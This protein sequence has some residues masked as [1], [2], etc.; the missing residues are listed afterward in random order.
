MSRAFRR[1]LLQD[2]AVY[3][4]DF[5][6]LAGE[7]PRAVQ[8]KGA[9]IR[10]LDEFQGLAFIESRDMP[11]L[12]RRLLKRLLILKIP[13]PDFAERLRIWKSILSERP[14]GEMEDLAS[15]F[16][17][18]AG[19]IEDAISAARNLAS[20]EGREQLCR[21]DIFE[22]CRMQS[23][24]KLSTLARRIVPRYR[25]EDV[26]L[27]SNG[28]EQLR[29]IEAYI[30][31][32]GKVFGEWG[33]GKKLSLGKGLNILFTG[34]SGTGKTMAAEALAHELGL[35][36]YKV[37]L[38]IVVSKYIGETEKNLSRIFAE[39][40]ESN[41]ILFFDEADAIFGKRSEVKD[42]H[43]RYANVEIG[44]LLQKMEEHEGIVVLATNL[45]RNLDEAFK[46]RMHFVVK[47]PFPGEES[48]LQIWKSL[49]PA[50]AR[51]AD[52]L[53]F[54]F[55]ARSFQI[56]G[57]NIKNVLVTAA[58][59]AAEDGGVISMKHLVRA[60]AREM[61]KIGKVCTESEFREYYDLVKGK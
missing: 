1:A 31:H 7:D 39:A 61:K 56:A 22:G 13:K 11:D 24:R 48:R 34:D 43:D 27:P 59:L 26:V 38:S 3:V 45:D 2:A 55:L 6:S 40:E 19:Q 53:D 32:Q 42:A 9:L 36:L 52:G 18:T 10:A 5:D 47:F 51:V 46:R 41:A 4:Q 12:G 21:E 49:L 17:L 28:T 37:D 58:F 14:D 35:E 50:E 44:Y 15:K 30:K 29:D 16:K 54:Q 60:T 23:S 33:F 25:L 57:G 8:L 20:L